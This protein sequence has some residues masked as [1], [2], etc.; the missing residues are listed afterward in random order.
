MNG[1]A[2]TV[3][4]FAPFVRFRTG[5]DRPR[6]NGSAKSSVEFKP[7]VVSGRAS[8]R[9]NHERRW[10]NPFTPFVRLRTGFDSRYARLRANGR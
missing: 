3:R 4:T 5:F 2:R 6:T 7:F 1:T 8:A 10:H 9:S